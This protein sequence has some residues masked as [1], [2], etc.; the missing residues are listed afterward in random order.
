L[1]GEVKKKED[2]IMME[3]IKTVCIVGT[4]FMGTQIGLQCAIHGYYVNMYDISSEAKEIGKETQKRMVG[5]MESSLKISSKQKEKIIER[6]NY[7]TELEK[8]AKEADFVIESVPEKLS[9]KRKV[10]SEIDEICPPKTIIATGASVI[11]VSSL[12]DA[13]ERADKVLNMHFYP[14][15]QQRPV[16][17]IMRG[18]RTSEET[19]KTAK[20]FANSIGLV[21]LEVKKEIAGFLFNR[22]WHAIKREALFLADGGYASFEDIDR[23]WILN[24]GMKVGI[25]GTM[26]MVGIDVINDVAETFY[27]ESGDERDK[28]PK[29]I[30]EKVEKGELGQ[31]TGKGFYTYPNPSFQNP[32]WLKGEE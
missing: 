5:E 10:F 6:I 13:T 23:A 16:V 15:I 19:I 7:T 28:P 14:P 21:P 20:K 9:L 30:K 11:K 1:A 2:F 17:E 22:I 4:G 18:S 3:K 12:E 25:F 31:K 27:N 26:D 8:A 24:T 32:N 29:I